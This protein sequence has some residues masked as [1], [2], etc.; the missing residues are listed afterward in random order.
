MNDEQPITYASIEDRYLKNTARMDFHRAADCGI[1]V[2]R[3]PVV[4]VRLTEVGVGDGEYVGIVVKPQDTDGHVTI[5]V[6]RQPKEVANVAR[7]LRKGQKVE[8]VFVAK[9]DLEI[10]LIQ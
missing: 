9:G 5:V 3:G 4:K 2:G 7:K 1:M 10:V 8:V 6:P